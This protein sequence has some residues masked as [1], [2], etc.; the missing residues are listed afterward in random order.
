MF[1]F[2]PNVSLGSH[3]MPH[4]CCSL[5]VEASHLWFL[6]LFPLQGQYHVGSSARQTDFI[7]QRPVKVTFGC[8]GSPAPLFF[9]GN[10]LWPSIPLAFLSLSFPPSSG[11]AS[12]QA[13]GW[14]WGM[15]AVDMGVGVG[16]WN[17]GGGEESLQ[18][19]GCLTEFCRVRFP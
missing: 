3:R 12:V 4:S 5:Q 6:S 19:Y 10:S 14:R 16:A 15:G 8:P 18:P 2:T 1:N 7:T 13:L 9:W 17:G 11:L